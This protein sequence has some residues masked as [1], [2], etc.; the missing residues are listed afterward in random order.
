LAEGFLNTSSREEYPLSGLQKFQKRFI[1]IISGLGLLWINSVFL[2]F[3]FQDNILYSTQTLSLETIRRVKETVKNSQEIELN[4]NHTRLHG[5][6]VKYQEKT[7]IPLIIYFGGQG[8]EISSVVEVSERFT[9]CDFLAYNY[10]GYGLSRGQPSEQG[11]FEDSLAIYD[12]ITAQNI[13][14]KD[15]IIVMGRSLGT[16]VAVYL[17]QQRKV[18]ALILVSPYDSITSVAQEKL[19]FIP[20]GL[21]NHNPFDSLSRISNIQCPLLMI[22]AGNDMM[23]TNW[24]SQKIFKNYQGPKSSIIIKNKGHNDL[25]TDELYWKAIQEFLNRVKG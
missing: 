25:M 5:W 18:K 19:P 10:R 1:C 23:I 14:D 9:G 24:H 22:I 4:T 8:D 7:G 20:V 17:A 21:I 16:G 15:N 11:I 12:D 13:T 6:L 2:L 3:W